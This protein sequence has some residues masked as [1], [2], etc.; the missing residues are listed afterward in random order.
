MAAEAIRAARSVHELTT[1]AVDAVQLIWEAFRHQDLDRIGA[2]ERVLRHVRAHA[3]PDA[4][5]Q[6]LAASVGD[7]LSGVRTMLA[8]GVPFTDRAMREINSLFDKGIE[9]LEC[10]RDALVTENRVLVR[11]VLAGSAQYAQLASDYAM[12]HQQRLV[13]GVCLPQASAVYL[14]L[15]EHLKGVGHQARR[16]A[17]ELAIRR[18]P[19]PSG[20]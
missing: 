8:D 2:A 14:S 7:L 6:Q 1:R 20:R 15:L 5:A 12:A 16:I 13:E 4:A 17:E 10:A 19:V 11:H 3:A 18:G 9:L